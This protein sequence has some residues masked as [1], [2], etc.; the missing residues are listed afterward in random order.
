MTDLL[1][2]SGIVTFP[3]IEGIPEEYRGQSVM[4]SKKGNG[5]YVGDVQLNGSAARIASQYIHGMLRHY[6]SSR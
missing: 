4:V 3:E 5:F 2:P 6:L 1:N